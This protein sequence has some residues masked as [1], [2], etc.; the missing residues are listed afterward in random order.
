MRKL[1]RT[2]PIIGMALVAATAHAACGQDNSDEAIKACLAQDLRDSDKR[3]NAV[4]T[5]LMALNDEA[6][7]TSLRDEQ[8][9]WLRNRDKAC[10]LSNKETDREK[11][12]QSILANQDQTVCVVRYT[13]SR[14]A[15]LDQALQQKAPG[16]ALEAPAAP[17][18]PQF[19]PNAKAAEVKL[20][21]GLSF[22]DEGYRAR[23][24]SSH[25]RGK[26]YY[27]VWIDRGRIAEAG[28]LLIT[29]GFS[30]A[31]GGVI[32]MVNVRRTQAGMPP[33]VIGMA[34]DLDGGFVYIHQDGGYKV[35]P[36]V[37]GAVVI[38]LTGP[39]AGSVNSSAQV[40]ELVERGLVKVNLGERP[41]AFPAPAGYKA[42]GEN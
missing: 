31:N 4:Y 27:E 30:S 15:V 34:L 3:I 40:R 38:P 28:D 16:K 35:A 21:A 37:A 33:V 2:L 18:A 42:W 20:P 7:K 10:K 6:G 23:T 17:K 14:V 32:K 22:E 25:E 41:F 39:Y 19:Q 26:W 1:I 13:F 8:R 12:L 36:G 29:P 9:N 24:A 5:S 11:W